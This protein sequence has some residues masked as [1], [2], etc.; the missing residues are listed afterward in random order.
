MVQL[1][2]ASNVRNSGGKVIS[3]YI[4][5]II[6]IL[7]ETRQWIQLTKDVEDGAEKRGEVN[8]GINEDARDRCRDEDR[9]IK[10]FQ[11]FDSFKEKSFKQNL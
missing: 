1:L 7:E 3:P 11:K 5:Y 9:F 8:G 6:C 2:L 4:C 10:K